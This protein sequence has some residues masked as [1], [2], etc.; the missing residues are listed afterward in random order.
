M[1]ELSNPF[2]GLGLDTVLITQLRAQVQLS[3]VIP[4]GG[5]PPIHCQLL[6]YRAHS[7]IK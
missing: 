7:L 3:C 2:L 1:E 6:Y 5:L 4:S